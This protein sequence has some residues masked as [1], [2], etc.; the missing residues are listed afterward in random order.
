MFGFAAASTTTGACGPE[1]R[2]EL[3]SPALRG[4]HILLVPEE[5]GSTPVP[6]RHHPPFQHTTQ[7]DYR[8]W[9]DLVRSPART[10]RALPT[11]AFASASTFGG[12]RDSPESNHDPAGW[13]SQ[14]HTSVLLDHTTTRPPLGLMRS[15]GD[16]RQEERA[17]SE[18]L[19]RVPSCPISASY[20]S[21]NSSP[22]STQSKIYPACFT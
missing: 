15:R 17:N 14:V 2:L 19:F 6:A 22:D 7:A 12:Q 8:W 9:M 21:H 16:Q 20:Q 18:A 3:L 4:T 13:N 11:S 5:A 1:D 10:R